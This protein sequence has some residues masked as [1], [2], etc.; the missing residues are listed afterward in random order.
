MQGAWIP[1]AAGQ[2]PMDVNFTLTP[3]ATIAGTVTDDHGEPLPDVL[4]QAF[5]PSYDLR[6][7]PILV[8][9]FQALTDDFGRYRLY[10]IDPAAYV[11]R[12]TAAPDILEIFGAPPNLNRNRSPQ[13]FAPTYHTGVTD[14][15][16]IEPL[17]VEAGEET[18]GLDFNLARNPQIS[19]RGGVS[20]TSV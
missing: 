20:G 8:P 19:I 12:A 16:G 6:G 9:K 3:A 1:I 2:R 17:K 11:I 7:N 4:I 18:Q 10:W 15:E 5:R 14:P 13:G